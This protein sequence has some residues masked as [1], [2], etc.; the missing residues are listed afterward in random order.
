[1]YAGSISRNI[2]NKDNG[3]P[4]INM[5]KVDTF[6]FMVWNNLSPKNDHFY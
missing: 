2:S 4:K 3:V 1:M 6:T 5:Q